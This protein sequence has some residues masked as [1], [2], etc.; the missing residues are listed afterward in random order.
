MF[1]PTQNIFSL[2]Q[3]SLAKNKA[4]EVKLTKHM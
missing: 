1:D 3:V 4:K 2:F